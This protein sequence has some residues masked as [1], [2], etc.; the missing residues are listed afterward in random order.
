MSTRRRRASDLAG[1]AAAL[2][3]AAAALPAQA[4]RL[5]VAVV[6]LAVNDL[7]VAG[8]PAEVRARLRAAGIVPES[9]LAAALARTGRYEPVEGARVRGALDALPDTEAGHCNTAACA[10]ALGRAT[11]VERVVTGEVRRVSA[12]IVHV[13]AFVFDGGTGALRYDE[14][15]EIKG[16]VYDLLPRAMPVL[17]RRLAGA[18][19]GPAAGAAKLT[20]ADVERLIAEGAARGHP[21]L[22]DRDLS[23]LDLSGLDFH[24]ADL[25]RSRLEG[26]RLVRAQLFGATLNGVV[27]T[28]ADF[29][30]A[31][32]DVAVLRGADLT[33]A[34]LR[35]AS[36]YATILI[37]A[38]LSD[39]DLG[40]ARLIAAAAG[41]TLRR[42]R[43]VN[44]KLGADPSNQ[45]M[46]LMRTD[47][48]DA[49]LTDADLTGAD[50]RK[51]NFTRAT[52]AGADLADA[53][54]R[55]AVL[56][57]VR[58]RE[59]ARGLDRARNLDKTI[60]ATP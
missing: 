51:V 16:D 60:V 21:D 59:L 48:S 58:G 38:D 9:L 5:R 53:D 54:L 46:G 35:D 39:A 1:A 41:A 22:R 50:L 25:S 20:R 42:A 52:L 31:T 4:P 30:G 37:G 23:G 56:T 43:L 28:G 13:R 27:A 32:L 19:A 7:S 34:T 24:E 14:D 8:A 40:S 10:R 29:S 3:V 15:L 36:L 2:L 57:D 12:I 26:T 44:A 18:E 11:G 55:G 47:L 6:P 33:H 49:D 45:P 17:A